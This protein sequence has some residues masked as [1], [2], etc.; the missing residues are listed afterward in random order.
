MFF[1]GGDDGRGYRYMC[2][3]AEGWKW[4]PDLRSLGSLG[5]LYKQYDTLGSQVPCSMAGLA[6]FTHKSARAL[7]QRGLLLFTFFLWGCVLHKKYQAPPP[8][9]VPGQ[10]PNRLEVIHKSVSDWFY[11]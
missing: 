7:A 2:K 6:M 10:F 9:T 11:K 1:Q 8:S 3:I 5:L 4:K